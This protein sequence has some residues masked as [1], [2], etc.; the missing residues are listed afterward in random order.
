MLVT[1]T[2][3]LHEFSEVTPMIENVNS[4]IDHDYAW[5]LFTDFKITNNSKK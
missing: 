4:N 1:I 3:D 2:S 5:Q